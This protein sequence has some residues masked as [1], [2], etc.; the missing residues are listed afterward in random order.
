MKGL[1]LKDIYLL[2]AY[3]KTYLLLLAFYAVLGFMNGASFFSI[4]IAVILLILPLNA[5]AYDEQARW[6]KFAVALPGGRRAVVRAKYQFLFLVLA[7]LFIVALAVNLLLL[8]AGRSADAELEG[9][10][11][12]VGG[13]LL[14]GT[15]LNLILFPLL[16]KFGTQK[17][18]LILALIMGVAF[19]ALGIGVVILSMGGGPDFQWPPHLSTPTPVLIVA[20]AAVLT[21]AVALISYRISCRVYDK[22]EF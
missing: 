3:G 18:R 20:A 11:L 16:F 6:D 14:A 1:L 12:S 21:A 13:T 4:L 22:K 10:L 2:K 19:A 15:L 8:A 5:F 7:G 17:S 9:V